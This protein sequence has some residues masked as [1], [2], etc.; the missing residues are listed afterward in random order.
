LIELA[1]SPKIGLK[2][3]KIQN[4]QLF[5]NIVMSKA[6]LRSKNAPIVG[7]V[8]TAVAIDAKSHKDALESTPVLYESLKGVEQFC[9]TDLDI[10]NVKHMYRYE[11][12]THTPALCVVFC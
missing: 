12:L 7:Q 2:I 8:A 5:K 11:L 6:E 10:I 9:N 1:S 4:V 3:E